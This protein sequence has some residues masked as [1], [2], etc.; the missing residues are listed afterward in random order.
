MCCN[1]KK[2]LAAA[3]LQGL[4]GLLLAEDCEEDARVAETR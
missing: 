2:Q 3:G 1:I 4:M